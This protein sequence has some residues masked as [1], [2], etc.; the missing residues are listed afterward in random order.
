[1]TPWNF[2][3]AMV[4]R[5]AAPALAA[6]CTVVLKPAEQSPLT[7]LRLEELWREA[8]GPA[9]VFQVLTTAEPAAV[10]AVFFDDPAIRKLTFTGSTEVGHPAGRAGG[11][12]R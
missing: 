2:P 5:K 11:A 12:G 7:A 8:G 10:S 3:A 9:D 6:G 1:M 4:T